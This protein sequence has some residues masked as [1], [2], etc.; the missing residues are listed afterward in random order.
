[1]PETPDHPFPPAPRRSHRAVLWLGPILA[2]YASA[3]VLEVFPGSVPHLAI[4]ALDVLSAAAF[5]LVDGARTYSLRTILVFAGLCTVVG[6][7]VENI[8]VATGFPFGR[9]QFLELMGPRVLGV[10]VLLGLA[11]LGMAYA[12]WR[13]ASLILGGRR[14]LVYRPALASVIMTAWD[15]AQDPVWG[16]VLHGWIWRDGG[17]WFGVPLSNYC[18]WLG[19][20]FLI[21][22]LFALYLR[23]AGR[24]SQGDQRRR[25][26][27]IFYGLCALGNVLETI[28]R[29]GPSLVADATGRIWRIADITRAAALVSILGMGSFALVAWL[30]ADR[31]APAGVTG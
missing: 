23:R 22:L 8:G 12:S 19:T 11:Y 31:K 30:R 13:V 2:S 28:P 25:W 15:L 3:R 18:G 17:A 5:A 6:N 29:P 27:V 4:V 21:Y 9:Y 24:A 14:G 7:V 26:A 16:T 1:M 20:V 10:P